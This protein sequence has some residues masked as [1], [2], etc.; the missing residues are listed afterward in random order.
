MIDSRALIDGTPTRN[1]FREVFR[2]VRRHKIAIFA[3]VVFFAAIAWIIASM[4][5]PHFAAT[6]AVTL[7]VSKVQVVDREVVSRLPL[8]TSTLRSEIDVMRS[9]SL[10]DEV[11]VK[12]G[13]GS[14]PAVA[15]EAHAWLSPWPYAARGIRDVLRRHFPGLI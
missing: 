7:N 13:L 1:S 4:T 8:E 11:V 2:F 12:L 5:P 3:P 9:R 10:N 15:R 6:S 14:D